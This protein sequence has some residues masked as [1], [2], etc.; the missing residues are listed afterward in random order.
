MAVLAEPMITTLFHYG[1]FD[2]EA[3][4]Q[5][6]RPLIAYCV[7]LLGIILVK[8]LA[9]AFYAQQDIRTPVRIATGVLI[10]TQLM[11]CCSCP[12]GGRPGAV[13]RP[14][15]LPERQPAVLGPAP[16]YLPSAAGLADVLR[17]A[18]DRLRP[19]GRG[20]LVRRPANRLDR[21][22]SSTPSC[23]GALLLLIGV[24]GVVYF[25]ALLAMGFRLRDFKRIAR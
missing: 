6:A 18:G 11:N 14:G 17:E 2:D 25:A 19:D 12:A 21:P 20:R 1:A 22:A 5:S 7:G 4:A 15:R 24:C 3:A 8:T 23:A 13:D 9:P 16:Q 10:A